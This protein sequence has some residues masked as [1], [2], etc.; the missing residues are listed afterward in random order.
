MAELDVFAAP[1]ASVFDLTAL[2]YWFVIQ[3][4]PFLPHSGWLT[5]RPI[6]S[7]D[8]MNAYVEVMGGKP[9]RIM[10]G[11][12]F[13]Q[14]MFVT[15]CIRMFKPAAPIETAIL[16][17][18][19]QIIGRTVIGV[20]FRKGLSSQGA[21]WPAMAAAVVAE[22]SV[23]FYVAADDPSFVEAAQLRFPG[24]TTVG[25]K[26]AKDANNP[27]GN[28]QAAI[29][30]FALA[31]TTRILGSAGSGFGELAALYGGISYDEIVG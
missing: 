17:A 21:F 2:P 28:E 12:Q 30:F 19:D 5:A 16:A 26:Q 8:A 11:Q 1:A 27:E 14:T 6:P 22:Q 4:A 25:F 31:R 7:E 18:F 29:D 3:D 23:L 20:H 24:Q 9:L 15:E 10:S 13:A